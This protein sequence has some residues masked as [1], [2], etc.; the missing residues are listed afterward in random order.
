MF[1]NIRLHT[2]IFTP[3]S[4]ALLI[5][6]GILG[7]GGKPLLRLIYKKP[8]ETAVLIVK[9]IGLLLVLAGMVII[10]IR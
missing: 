8:T 7:Y 2:E 5:I 3:L 9:S 6:G 1:D 10:F 4:A